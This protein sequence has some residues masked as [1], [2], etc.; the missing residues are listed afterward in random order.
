MLPRQEGHLALDLHYLN[1]IRYLNKPESDS[2][3]ISIPI[4]TVGDSLKLSSS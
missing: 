4:V 3:G 2:F 1:A